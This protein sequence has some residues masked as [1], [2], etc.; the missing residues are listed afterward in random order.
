LILLEKNLGY[1]LNSARAELDVMTQ[2]KEA[3]KQIFAGKAMDDFDNVKTASFPLPLKSS[4]ISRSREQD[5]K[6]FD[7]TFGDLGNEWAQR[8]EEMK[9]VRDELSRAQHLKAER[10]IVV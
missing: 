3:R 7:E 9:K 2:V 6:T 4:T 1:T 10:Q 8:K 5:A